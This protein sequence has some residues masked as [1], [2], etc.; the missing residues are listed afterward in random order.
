MKFVAALSFVALAAAAVV[1]PRHCAGNNCN[2]AVTGT[3]P[4]LLPLTERSSSCA[5]FLLTTVTP[6]AST[7]TVTV[8]EE[9]LPTPTPAKRAAQLN[10]RQE[11]VVPTAIPEFAE[12]CADAAEFVSACSCFGVTGSVTTAPAPT[13]TVTTTIDYCEDI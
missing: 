8:D 4:G 3:R 6:A 12:N 10:A 2:R 9:D 11:T 1:E 13:V 7:V 5:S